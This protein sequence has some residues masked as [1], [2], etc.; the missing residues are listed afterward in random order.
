MTGA[1]AF[2]GRPVEPGYWL[3]APCCGFDLS[4]PFLA[5]D[6]SRNPDRFGNYHRLYLVDGL[7]VLARPR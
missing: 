5:D 7:R 3:Q 6:N 4:L 2:D 1:R